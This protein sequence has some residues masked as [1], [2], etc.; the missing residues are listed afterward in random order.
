[1]QQG[2][3]L[4]ALKELAGWETL[5]IVKRYAHL[6]PAHLLAYAENVGSESTPQI[7][8]SDEPDDVKDVP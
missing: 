7:R 8:H 3:P 6:A 5:E 2:T 4:Y 1:V